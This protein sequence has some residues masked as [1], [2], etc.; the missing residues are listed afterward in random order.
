M[1]LFS[2]VLE[3]KIKSLAPG[4]NRLAF[5]INKEAIP[6]D[7][8][9]LAEDGL[10]ELAIQ[11]KETSLVC[12]ALANFSIQLECD[13]CLAPFTLAL[14]APFTFIAT[15]ARQGETQN[16]EDNFLYYSQTDKVLD[17]TPTVIEELSVNLP[18]KSLCSESC[19]GLC[20]VCGCNLNEK[21]C[22]C[23]STTPHP[24]RDALQKLKESK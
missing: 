15:S 4:H 10:L 21:T 18:M 3:I 13:R 24:V 2:P 7:I 22:H 14:E 19:K 5:P 9:N 20:P 16:L 8:V 12:E 11:N 6:A 23:N 17:I 1:Y